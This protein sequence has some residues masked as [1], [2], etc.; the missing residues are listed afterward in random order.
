MHVCMSVC[1]QGYI[2]R[3]RKRGRRYGWYQEQVVRVYSHIYDSHISVRYICMYSMYIK[4][5]IWVWK[6][7]K[8]MV[9]PGFDPGTLTTSRWCDNQLHH[10]TFQR[11]DKE[12]VDRKVGKS[13]EKQK[14]CSRPGSNQ[15][16]LDLQSNAATSWATGAYNKKDEKGQIRSTGR[17]GQKKQKREWDTSHRKIKRE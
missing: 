10:E 16:P 6:K 12:R 14:E 13:G 7:Q 8:R 17:E 2:H 11:K 3:H 9:S 5:Y 15:W 1:K 4:V